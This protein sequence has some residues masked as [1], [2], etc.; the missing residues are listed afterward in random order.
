M[1]QTFQP[2]TLIIINNNKYNVLIIPTAIRITITIMIA[3]TM[4]MV[5][6]MIIRRTRKKG[7]E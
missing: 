2:F 7:E 1:T 4:R 6:M 5:K 3:I